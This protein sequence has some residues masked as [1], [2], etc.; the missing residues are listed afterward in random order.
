MANTL[1]LCIDE[2]DLELREEELPSITDQE[3]AKFRISREELCRCFAKG[4]RLMQRYTEVDGV[5]PIAFE[6]DGKWKVGICGFSPLSDPSMQTGAS[7]RLHR[8]GPMKLA[9]TLASHRG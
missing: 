6:D 5:R 7:V 9:R 8:E 2:G 1:T 4:T 3:L